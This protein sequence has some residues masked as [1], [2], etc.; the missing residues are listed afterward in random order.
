MPH[1]VQTLLSDHIAQ[2]YV[3]LSEPLLSKRLRL[4][5]LVSLMSEKNVRVLLPEFLVSAALTSLSN[6]EI[7]ALICFQVYV[8]DTDD[9]FSAEAITAIGVCSRKVPA[10]AQDC[11]RT[12][13][14]LVRSSNGESS[15]LLRYEGECADPTYLACSKDIVIAQ[16]VLVLRSLLQSSSLTSTI[17]RVSTIQNLVHLLLDDQIKLS[18][19]QANIYWLIGQ[20]ASIEV[21]DEL[22]SSAASLG[23][24]SVRLGALHFATEVSS[25]L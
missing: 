4:K 19:A 14:Q 12:L 20:Y 25:F 8:K 24:D 6:F 10:V 5:I 23:P 9:I 1:L 7:D 11:L 2:F 21:P 13:L 18:S 3:R 15:F 22:L 16:S 17:S